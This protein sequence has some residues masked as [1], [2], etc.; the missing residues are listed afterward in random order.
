MILPEDIVERCHVD[1]RYNAL[2]GEGVLGHRLLVDYLCPAI[3]IK[4]CKG[5][6]V[7]GDEVLLIYIL[8]RVWMAHVRLTVSLK[9]ISIL[10]P[11]SW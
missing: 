9:C 2:D 5:I 1:V 4:G 3:R 11:F 8:V 7:I 10:L 6:T